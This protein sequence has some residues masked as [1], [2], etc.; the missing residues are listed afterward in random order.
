MFNIAIN[1]FK[2][3]TRN[4]ILYMILFFG[5]LMIIFSLTL[6]S[7]SMWQTSKIV[8]D[9]GLAMIEIFWLIIV[10]F[11]WSQ[12]LFKEIEW[13][14]IYLILSKPI[15]RYEFILGKFGGFTMILALIIFL[16]S[17]IFWIILFYSKTPFDSL[18]IYSIFFI[19]LKLIVLFAIILFFSSFISSILSIILTFLIYIISHSVTAIIDMAISWN[20]Y[21]MKNFGKILYIIFPNFEA[22]NIK[23]V[24]F[25]PVKIN[26]EYI[27]INSIYS[28]L[29]LVI[30]LILTVLI[31]NKKTFEN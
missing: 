5:V 20:N 15:S 10:I 27:A 13:K 19:F 14:T 11:I 28:I 25:S 18:I 21:F 6:A 16:Q 3:L 23:N 2:E 29:Y 7:L 17:L 4:K 24:I 31:F 26:I 30:I 9:F 8:L 22:L 1:T 12:I